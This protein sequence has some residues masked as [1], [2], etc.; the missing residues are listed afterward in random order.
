MKEQSFKKPQ[1]VTLQLINLSSAIL[2]SPFFFD[3]M[4]FSTVEPYLTPSGRKAQ[5]PSHSQT[6]QVISHTHTV[7]GQPAAPVYHPQSRGN[8]R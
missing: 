2:S 6:N 4:S 7:S 1:K 3:L 5:S 8:G